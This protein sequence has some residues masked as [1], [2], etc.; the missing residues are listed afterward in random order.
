MIS[1]FWTASSYEMREEWY[2][3]YFILNFLGIKKSY[4]NLVHKHKPHC[5]IDWCK[6][7][8]HGTDLKHMVDQLYPNCYN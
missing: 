3:Y 7:N 2:I 1:T 4:S 8:H 5:L 6:R